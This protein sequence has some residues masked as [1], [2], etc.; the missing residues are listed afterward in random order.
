MTNKFSPKIRMT[1]LPNDILRDILG[2]LKVKDLVGDDILERYIIKHCPNIDHNRLF[3]WLSK[4]NKVNNVILLLN[5]RKEKDYSYYPDILQTA[6]K[7]SV[8]SKKLGIAK[9]ICKYC[10]EFMSEHKRRLFQVVYTEITKDKRVSY[11]EQLL[12][13]LSLLG[14]QPTYLSKHLIWRTINHKSSQTL[15]NAL[16]RHGI[17]DVII[18]NIN[19]YFDDQERQDLI[20]TMIIYNNYIALGKLVQCNELSVSV[21]DLVWAS[22]VSCDKTVVVCL[23]CFKQKRF[24]QRLKKCIAHVCLNRRNDEIS[25]RVQHW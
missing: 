12:S 19:V 5:N 13:L 25:R 4:H 2:N 1:E 21:N 15:C 17:M 9:C 7:T 3:Q 10:P 11:L 16:E 6:F 23:D 20:S 18:S 8:H 22:L 24:N 14:Y